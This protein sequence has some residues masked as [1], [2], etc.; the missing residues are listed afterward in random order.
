VY[1][2]R[3]KV[4]SQIVIVILKSIIVVADYRKNTTDYYDKF[5]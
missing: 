3:T 5:K 1:K 2:Q 4:K